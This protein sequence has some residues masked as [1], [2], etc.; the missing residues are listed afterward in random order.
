VA[1]LPSTGPHA[2]VFEDVS[3]WRSNG[4]ERKAL[5][6]RIDWNVDTGEQWGIVGP[7]GAGKTTLLRVAA[8]EIRPSSGSAT[9][10]GGRLG[11]T[12][13]PA[14]RRRIG[15][16]APAI[17]RRFYPVQLAI[18][19]V[20]S[21]SSGTI[22]VVDESAPALREHAHALLDAVGAADLSERT[23]ASCSEGERA[24]ILLARALAAD[25]ELLALDEPAA[26]LDL[27]GRELLLE[28]FSRV[29]G[30]RP[31]LTTL[32]V[33]HHI[34]E[35]PATTSHALLLRA[36]T[37][38]AAGPVTEALTAATLTECFGMPLQVERL[39]GRFFV[40]A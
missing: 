35:L 16:V 34:E 32:T 20:L 3:V 24:R 38:V 14:L 30:D 18:D 33:T 10:L 5:L 17:A 7:N 9:V 40:R 23:F 2:V 13:M 21:G 39:G 22:L 11:R 36:G 29:T 8:A 15:F 1:Q 12:S 28:T 25:A 27:P 19:V 4:G 31:A 37:V 6:D 26:G